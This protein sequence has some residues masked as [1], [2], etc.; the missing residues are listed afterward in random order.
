[1]NRHKVFQYPNNNLLCDGVNYE[2]DLLSFLYDNVFKDLVFVRPTNQQVFLDKFKTDI[3]YYGG[4]N[5]W[6]S[7]RDNTFQLIIKSVSIVKIAVVF[8]TIL[9]S[10]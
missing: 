5:P 7:T 8:L 1:M 4:F 9:I 10:F 3:I 6:D 2:E